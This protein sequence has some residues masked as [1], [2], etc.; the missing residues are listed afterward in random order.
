MDEGEEFGDEGLGE[1]VQ[2][3]VGLLAVAAEEEVP[4]RE[5]LRGQEEEL[6]LS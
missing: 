5:A 2:L 4:L 3:A 1:G 6:L